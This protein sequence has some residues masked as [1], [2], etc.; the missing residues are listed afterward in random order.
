MGKGCGNDGGVI[1]AKR[2]LLVKTATENRAGDREVAE[3]FAAARLTTCA[4]S[5]E[6]LREPIV[7]DELGNLFNKE[8]VLSFVLEGR[9]ASVPSFAHLR[10]IKRDVVAVRATPLPEERRRAGDAAET[11]G[12]VAKGRAIFQCPLTLTEANGRQS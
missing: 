9:A 12:S 3:E 11:A 10:S 5:G 1:A 8:S 6:P 2:A 4:L 7:C